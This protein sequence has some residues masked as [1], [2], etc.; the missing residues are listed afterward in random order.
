M[1]VCPAAAVWAAC[2]K[3]PHTAIYPEARRCRAEDPNPQRASRFNSPR[4]PFF[5]AIP[6]YF[7]IS[8]AQFKVIDKGAALGSSTFV[9]IRNF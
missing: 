3:S 6:P 1:A 2:T 5:L 7:S 8:D 4:R 9:L